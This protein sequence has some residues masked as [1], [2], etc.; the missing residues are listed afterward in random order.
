MFKSSSY[1]KREKNNFLKVEL[2]LSWD[3]FGNK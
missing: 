3:G 2:C 1:L